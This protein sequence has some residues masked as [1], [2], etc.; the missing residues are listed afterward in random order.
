MG[1]EGAID[2]AM[3]VL[4]RKPGSYTREDVAEIQ[5]HGSQMLVSRIL[6]LVTAHG[7]RIA[8]PGEF[9][10]RAFMNGRIDLTQAEAVM[11]M[12]EADSDRAMKSAMR[13]L[14]GGVSSFVREVE[15]RIIAM[16]AGIAATI[17][18]PDEVD[19]AQ[20]AREIDGE[21][22]RIMDRIRNACDVRMGKIDEEGI[23]VAL[24]GQPNVGKSSLLNAFIGQ[25]R[26][27]VTS[28]PG[29][30]RDVLTETVQM[31]GTKVIIT[32]TA[33]IRSTEDEV[34][35]IGVERARKAYHEADVR[36]LVLD[37]SAIWEKQDEEIAPD[38]ILINKSDLPLAIS[39]EKI[40]ESYAGIPVFT[41]SSVTGDGLDD[42]RRQIV[43]S[44][45]PVFGENAVITQARHAEAAMKAC[46]ELKNARTA[47]A[48][49][50]P[51]DMVE[52][53]LSR[54]LNLLGEI[55]GESLNES[56]LDQVFSRFC[57]GK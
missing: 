41:V 20:S 40:E 32:D 7:G 37:G 38:M 53:D 49:N 27:I 52:I 23:R 25:D 46:E 48:Q 43:S 22:A 29:T 36:I 8:S 10:Y 34:E 33:G 50:M 1:E 18:F 4:I 2:E 5:C 9:T 35:R 44:T 12:I 56:V 16:R 26:A 17:D 24:Y 11:K 31:Y 51:L 57:V 21:C 30:T 45:T 47:I 3:A 6:S 55:T 15:D 13:Q 28:I 54:A 19:E 39:E 14:E 42:V